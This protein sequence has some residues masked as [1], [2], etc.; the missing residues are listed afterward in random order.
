MYDHD[1]LLPLLPLLPSSNRADSLAV[2][3]AGI[4]QYYLV[5]T[6]DITQSVVL[7]LTYFNLISRDSHR[8]G[9][10][11]KWEEING[12][13]VSHNGRETITNTALSSQHGPPF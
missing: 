3:S 10:V 4:P 13:V 5:S 8:S 2:I 1:I 6:F 12:L 7:H 11:I 9:S